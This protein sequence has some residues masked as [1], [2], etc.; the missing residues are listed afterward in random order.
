[1]NDLVLEMIINA[2]FCEPENLGMGELDRCYPTK[3]TNLELLGFLG[4]GDIV[5]GK[6]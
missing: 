2:P 3:Q 1:M 5:A 4:L 6:S